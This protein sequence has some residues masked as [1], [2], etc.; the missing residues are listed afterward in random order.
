MKPSLLL[1]STVLLMLELNHTPV[2][3]FVLPPS[4]PIIKPS[5][6]SITTLAP[7]YRQDSPTG[8]QA[9][10]VALTSM[11]SVLHN[12]PSFVLSTVLLLSIFGVS[13]ERRT[14]VGKALSAPL[15]TMALALTVANLGVI[16]FASPVC[17]LKRY[18]LLRR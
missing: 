7:F 17:E 2:N 11:Q 9:M 10:P 4:R 13:L 8:L 18:Y 14:T 6:R 15:A 16:P 5:L 12:D 1:A 3:G